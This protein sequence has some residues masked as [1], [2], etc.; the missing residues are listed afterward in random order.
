MSKEYILAIMEEQ[1]GMLVSDIKVEENLKIN[2]RA[3]DAVI[4]A[5]FFATRGNNA[6]FNENSLEN[7]KSTAKKISDG[8]KNYIPVIIECDVKVTTLDG[9]EIDRM[10]LV[11]KFRESRVMELLKGLI[12]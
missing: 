9:D 4:G 1:T 2:V 10:K 5:E 6:E 7:A 12:D 3:C 8:E 11:D